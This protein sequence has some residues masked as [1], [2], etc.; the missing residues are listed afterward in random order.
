VKPIGDQPAARSAQPAEPVVEQPAARSP[1]PAEPVVRE[2]EPEP[3]AEERHVRV[4]PEPE[5]ESDVV[6]FPRSEPPAAARETDDDQLAARLVALQMAVAGAD[7]G[8]VEGHLLVNFAVG[9]ATAILDDVFGRGT[10]STKR[11]TWPEAAGD[12]SS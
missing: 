7:R 3:V 9:D 6:E 10:G 2:P 4:A 5:A 8:E 11:V 1:Q 12:G